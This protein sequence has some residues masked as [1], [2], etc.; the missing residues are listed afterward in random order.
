MLARSR[1]DSCGAWCVVRGACP[2]YAPRLSKWRKLRGMNE[3]I[4][5]A[6]NAFAHSNLN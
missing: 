1:V 6:V 4:N 3:Y 5:I 2:E